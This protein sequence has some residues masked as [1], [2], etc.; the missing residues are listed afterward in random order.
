MATYRHGWFKVLVWFLFGAMTI[1]FLPGFV[2]VWFWRLSHR[3]PPWRGRRV[4]MLVLAVLAG[5]LQLLWANVLI[6]D[7][8]AGIGEARDQPLGRTAASATN[9]E[10]GPAT[11]ANSSQ[12]DV[13]I[14]D[15]TAAAPTTTS[16]ASVPD[17]INAE[18][19]GDP[20]TG[21]QSAATASAVP[22]TSAP[23]TTEA[24][25]TTPS[26]PRD[27]AVPATTTTV[28]VPS[29]QPATSGGRAL[30]TLAVAEEGDGGVAY[31]RDLYGSWTRV[32]SGCDTR[33]AVLEEERRADG[34][35]LS[36]YDGMVTSD[37][38]RLDID[39]MVPLAEA[40]SSG[41]WQ[42]SPSRR[43]AYAND[44]LHPA[45]LAAVS[46]SSNRSKGSRDPSGWRPTDTSVWCRY[47]TDW[48]TVKAAWELTADR[49]EVAA[50]GEML[51]TCDSAVTITALP[52]RETT[53]TGT[54]STTTSAA[55]VTAASCP[56]TSAA[57]DPCAQVPELGN[58]SNDVNCGDIPSASSH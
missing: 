51:D 56:Y 25:A 47:A 11:T 1:F 9:I 4:S 57:G 20:T 45:A 49:A 53:T 42:W 38:S 26:A 35:W 43:T 17:A 46:A 54:V 15:A 16:Q 28:A 40:H 18:A 52:A 31:D 5:L 10:A 39:H 44:L 37:A 8:L 55:S 12:V 13:E 50:L 2:A 41:A 58:L 19:G 34:T 27:T 3:P 32:R 14:E 24:S 29:T 6:I 21:A 36:W 30:A 48:V 33:C 23:A 7:P 22:P